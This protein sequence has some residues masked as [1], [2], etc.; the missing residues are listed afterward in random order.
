M[1]SH[2]VP[3]W[4]DIL[5]LGICSRLRLTYVVLVDLT[6]YFYSLRTL[7]SAMDFTQPFQA[8]VMPP[9]L[10]ICLLQPSILNVVLSQ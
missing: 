7:L 8:L 3:V 10:R 6:C 1:L 2:P 4:T 5:A 9:N